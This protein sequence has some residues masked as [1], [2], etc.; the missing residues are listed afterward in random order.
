[1]TTWT[2]RQYGHFL[3]STCNKGHGDRRNK[4]GTWHNLFLYFTCD[5]G[6][7][8][9]RAPEGCPLNIFCFLSSGCLK[10][11]YI[12]VA[13]N[14]FYC[15]KNAS[16]CTRSYAHD[17]MWSSSCRATLAK[18]LKLHG[19]KRHGFA[20][21]FYCTCIYLCIYLRNVSPSCE[22]RLLI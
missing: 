21:T 17:K 4:K 20:C 9:S 16:L 10:R 1:M 2:T 22:P 13:G 6:D 14:S 12:P 15:G 18:G 5:I 11:K 3:K 8:S 7:P 19:L